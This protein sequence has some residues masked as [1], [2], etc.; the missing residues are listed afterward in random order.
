M[1]S[2]SAVTL[3]SPLPLFNFYFMLTRVGYSLMQQIGNVIPSLGVR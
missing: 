3:Y 2:K 1:V